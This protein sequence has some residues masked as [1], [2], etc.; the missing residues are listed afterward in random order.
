MAKPA[1]TVSPAARRRCKSVAQFLPADRGER[2]V[3]QP[4]I[5]A[6]IVGH[7][8]AERVERA[9][10][11]HLGCGDEIAAADF[12]RIDAASRAAIASS[13]PLAHE[14]ALEASRRAVGAARRLVGEADAAGHAIGARRG[15]ARAAW[16][17]RDR[18]R[19]RHGCAHRRPDR[20]K[21]RRR[22]RGAG[23]LRRRRRARG[24]AAGASD[25]SRSDARGGLRSISPARPSRSAPRQASTSSG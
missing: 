24:N 9:R 22:W 15:R 19:S 7:F 17:R 4:G 20:E 12:D 14:R 6:G 21:T 3:E 11:R 5:V 18:E 25:W 1:P 8:G 16:W 13:K 23:P 2:L 10:I